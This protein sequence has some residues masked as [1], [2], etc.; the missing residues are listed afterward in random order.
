[1]TALPTPSVVAQVTR[2]IADTFVV[3]EEEAR[4]NAEGLVALAEGWGGVGASPPDWTHEVKIRFGERF[5][6]RSATVHQKFLERK[7]ATY[8]AYES[9]IRVRK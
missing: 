2:I 8:A 1:M 6:W 4:E 9:Y 7:K 5:A 3:T